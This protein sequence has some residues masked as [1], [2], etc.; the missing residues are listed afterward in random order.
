MLFTIA[1][2]LVVL[3]L[4]VQLWD[5]LFA[6]LFAAVITVACGALLLATAGVIFLAFIR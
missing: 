4:V 1:L 5:V 2:A 3:W 6:F